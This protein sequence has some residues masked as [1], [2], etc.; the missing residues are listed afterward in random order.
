MLTSCLPCFFWMISAS[1]IS[2]RLHRR[3]W[4]QWVRAVPVFFLGAAGTQTGGISWGAKI[5]WSR[6]QKWFWNTTKNIMDYHWWLVAMI[7]PKIMGMGFSKTWYQALSPLWKSPEIAMIIRHVRPYLP[8]V[9][10]KRDSRYSYIFSN[11]GNGH[12]VKH[13]SG[14]W[15]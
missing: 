3:G 5:W 1:K 10:K 12:T 8:S 7:F 11:H 6:A 4:L 14:W 13:Q 15:P 2:H 9:I